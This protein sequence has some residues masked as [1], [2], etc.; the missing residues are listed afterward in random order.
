MTIL[1]D[2]RALQDGKITGVT[3]YLTNLLT[4]IFKKDTENTFILW[5]NKYRNITNLPEFNFPNVKIIQTRVPNKL[6]NLCFKILN[7][8]KVDKLVTKKKIDAVFIPDPRFAPV[9]KQAK[10]IITFHDLSFTHFPKNFSFKTRLYHKILNA[11]KQAL[12][13]DK[14]IA[15]S[16]FTKDDLIKT[17]GVS[18]DKIETV[19]EGVIKSFEKEEDKEK[20]ERIKVK[21]SLPNKFFFALFT[22]DPRK[23]IHGLIK[24]FD[25]FQKARGM[26]K[27]NEAYY[28]VIGGRKDPVIFNLGKLPNRKD[29]IYTDFIDEE[30]KIGLYSLASAFIYPSFYEGFGLPVLEAMKTKTPVITSNTSALPEVLGEDNGILVNPYDITD[31]SKGMGL[32]LKLLENPD[33]LKKKT[34]RA[35]SRA[36]EL[37]WTKCAK[38]HLEIFEKLTG[39]L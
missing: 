24:G 31:I 11:K 28:L 23:N 39:V 16:N 14:I 7:L 6:L 12:S 34:E 3:T 30:D 4:E 35:Y 17:F 32:I 38:Q 1:V 36:C 27:A 13:A 9:S 10:K 33:E 21:Y 26:S 5:A 18:E 2:I 19:Y 20:L 8:P 25:L 37:S 29:I 22:L 15:V